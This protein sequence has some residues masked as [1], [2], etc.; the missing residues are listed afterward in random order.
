[1]TRSSIAG[2]LLCNLQFADDIDLLGGSEEEVQQL[3]ERLKKT[4]AGW[5]PHKPNQKQNINKGSKDQTGAS[6]LSH[7]KASNTME[8]QRHQF[9]CKD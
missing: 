3:T 4:A 8:K 1:M 7:D 5:D 9:S 2:C 6:K